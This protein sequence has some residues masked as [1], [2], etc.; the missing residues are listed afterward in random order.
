MGDYVRFALKVAAALGFRQIT[1]AAFFAKALKIAQGKG[2]THASRGLPNLAA[3]GRWTLVQTGNRDLAQSVARA[4][5][6]RQAL[7][8]LAGAD[9]PEVVA[10]VGARMLAALRAFAGQAP[11]LT[12][13][14]LD[15]SGVT[16]WQGH[17]PG[18]LSS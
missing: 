7:E 18:S 2:H 16:L 11:E 17:S 5:T 3:L 15:F 10:E 12:G 1:V 4:N 13:V 6:A 9:A 8:I 14:I